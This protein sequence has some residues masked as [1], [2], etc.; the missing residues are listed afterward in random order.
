M[1]NHRGFSCG[2]LNCLDRTT[3]FTDGARYLSCGIA[4]GGAVFFESLAHSLYDSN[5][6][7]KGHENQQCDCTIDSEHDNNGNHGK[8]HLTDTVQGPAK[9]ILSLRSI[10]TKTI[11]GFSWRIWNGMCSRTLQ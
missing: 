7:H 2:Y 11:Q 10:V 9:R 6:T 1:I 8:Q 4:A 3:Y 5:D